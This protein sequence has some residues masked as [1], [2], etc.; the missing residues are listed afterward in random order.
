MGG[1]Y[2]IP[3]AFFAFIAAAIIVPAWLQHRGRVVALQAI[4]E[5]A[6]RGQVIDAALIER[7]MPPRRMAVGKFF[8]II[9]F[10]FGAPPFGVGVGLIAA[11]VFTG[12]P[13][14]VGGTINLC[15][16][17]LL[18]SLGLIVLRTLTGAKAPRWDFATVTALVCLFLGVCGIGVCIGLAL[19]RQAYP[20]DA[21][22]GM[23]IGSLVNG[24]SGIALTGLGV[25]LIRVF[26]ERHSET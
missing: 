8:S 5:A 3:V 20:P 22:A 13:T 6:A 2:I 23:L 7:L 26:G 11:A 12:Q 14:M 18:V 15:L 19:G 9:C 16:G 17:A 10:L 21:S 4:G 24:G 1:I 25:F